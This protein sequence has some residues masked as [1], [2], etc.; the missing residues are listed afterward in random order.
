[1]RS[2]ALIYLTFL[3]FIAKA[4]S[5]SNATMLKEL[6]KPE[7]VLEWNEIVYD[8]K[9]PDIARRWERSE[10]HG[11]MLMQGIKID[12]DGNIYISTARWNGSESPST[13]SKVVKTSEGYKLQPYP[14]EQMNDVMNPEGIKSV[15]GFE[16]DRN[17]IMWILDQGHIGEAPSNPGDEKLIL[18][19][20]T[21]N[22][23]IKRYIF[24]D[25][26][27]DKTSS[28]LNDIVVDND[29]G[30]AYIT[31]SGI[32]SDPLDGGL[33]IYDSNRN[34]ARRIFDASSLTSNDP[35]FVFNMSNRPVSKE[36]EMRTGAN[37]I[38]L[39]GDKKILYWTNEASNKL[40][41]IKTVLLRDF[42]ISESS[43]ESAVK[44]MVLPS[45]TDGLTS[46]R[47]NNIYLS[48][49]MLNGVLKLNAV[50][51]QISRFVYHPEMVWPDTFAWH[52]D[53]SL[54]LLSNHLDIWV[55]GD[56][57]FKDP[58]EPNFRIWRIPISA[59]PYLAP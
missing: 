24:S 19:N 15:L 25:E 31:D 58:N 44:T 43:L 6:V 59:Q 54:Y 7:V 2:K 46:D 50:T 10:I 12:K 33:I 32:Y 49:L 16:I 34:K 21:K 36:G 28:F 56:M 11:K 3:L 57:N 41:S 45:N 8:V 22:K 26:D 51:G 40:Y 18:W 17:N 48:A 4:T 53:G 29:S 20:I 55:D 9:D 39:T 47:D 35:N 42:R 13:L 52:P 37:G 14:S 23:E 27:T 38:A 30:F 5:V 1:M